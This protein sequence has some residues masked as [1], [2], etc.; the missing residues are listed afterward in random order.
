[1]CKVEPAGQKGVP[2]SHLSLIAQG[3]FDSD[4]S[5]GMGMTCEEMQ[6]RL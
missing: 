2:E 6:G 4:R 5:P 3:G 1:M